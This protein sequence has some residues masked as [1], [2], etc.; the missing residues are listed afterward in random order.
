MTPE[1]KEEFQKTHGLQWA[2]I[3]NMSSFNAGLIAL[4]M[5]ALDVI[6]NLTDDQ[7]TK[8]SVTILAALRGRLQHESELFGLPIMTEE[9]STGDIREKYPDQIDEAW[10]ETQRALQQSRSRLP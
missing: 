4:N 3:V 6:R 8:N 5:D 7:I 1:K 2:K 10:E 9:P